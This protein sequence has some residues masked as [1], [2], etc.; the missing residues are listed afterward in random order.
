MTAYILQ[1]LVDIRK[2]REN[3]AA[4]EAAR[5]RSFQ[6]QASEAVTNAKR[7]LEEFRIWRTEEKDRLYNT[8][9]NQI[10]HMRDLDRLKEALAELDEREAMFM[11]RIA[12][13]E[14]QLEEAVAVLDKAR[15]AFREATRNVEKLDEHRETWET[16]A[17]REA[18]RAADLE[19]EE[20]TGGGRHGNAE[21][22][23]AY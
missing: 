17:A 9:I 2:M 1:D 8:I 18:E 5:A 13:A 22:D 20:F 3:R 23:I 21:D 19:M 14:R 16:E 6:D 4:Q 12:D 11:K 10:V 7:Q 15:A